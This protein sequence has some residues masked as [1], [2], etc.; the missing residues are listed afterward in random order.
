MRFNDGRKINIAI[1]LSTTLLLSSCEGGLIGLF[2]PEP[3]DAYERLTD[4]DILK[5]AEALQES[6]E[7][8]IDGEPVL[9]SNK[10]SGRA[11]AITP[12]RTFVTEDGVFC[13]EYIETLVVD[14]STE[15]IENTGCRDEAGIWR[16]VR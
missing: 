1:A 11:G 8:K 16:W 7:G 15:N 10:I 12:I 14:G 5:A 3:G 4:G 13:R 2:E 9:W 6:L